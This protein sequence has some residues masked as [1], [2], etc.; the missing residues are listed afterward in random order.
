MPNLP[1]RVAIVDDQD[2]YRVMLAQFINSHPSAKVVAAA[3]GAQ[4]ARRLFSEVEVDV[5]IIDVEL[6]DGNGVAL[7]ISL[8]RLNPQLSVLLLS[9]HD[10]MDLVLSLP[11]D[12]IQGWS[13]LSKS[14]S[15]SP[16]LLI[17]TL[18][19]TANGKTVLDPGLVSRSV[20]RRGSRMAKL[21]E[22]QYEVLQAV[23]EGLSNQAIAHRL[24]LSPRSVENHLNTAY[25]TLGLS[26]R[27]TLNP[28]VAAV[29]QLLE[30]TSRVG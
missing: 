15:L 26:N 9:N 29:L 17:R 18:I 19:D 13:Y 22:R 25:E 12:L 1:L 10:V 11:R 7:G 8:R 30:E 3:S 24:K 27:D 28:R 21:T 14:S 6:G 16:E 20:P 5:A 4:E 2:L 23:A